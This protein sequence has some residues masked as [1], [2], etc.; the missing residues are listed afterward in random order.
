MLSATEEKK[1]GK[2]YIVLNYKLGEQKG[3]M[4]K[5]IYKEKPEVNNTFLN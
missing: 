3:H 4:R 2:G 5:M 1:G